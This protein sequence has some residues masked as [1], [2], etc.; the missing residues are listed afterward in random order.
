MANSHVTSNVVVTDT[1]LGDLNMTPVAKAVTAASGTVETG[2][3]SITG[4]WFQLYAPVSSGAYASI[5]GAKASGSYITY[6]SKTLGGAI[7][8]V[9]TS[10]IVF[11]FGNKIQG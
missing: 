5:T 8:T 3:T 1:V 10:G 6:H 9:A 11:A 4:C 7:P 2:L